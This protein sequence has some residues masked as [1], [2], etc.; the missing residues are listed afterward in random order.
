MIG[1]PYY[2]PVSRISE[3]C[4]VVRSVVPI[5]VAVVLTGIGLI[6]VRGG[7]QPAQLVIGEALRYPGIGITD[8]S[9]VD[10][11]IICVPLMEDYGS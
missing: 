6:I 3:D 2:C 7:S 10:Q 8:A 11:Y 1:I 4:P 5:D 9:D